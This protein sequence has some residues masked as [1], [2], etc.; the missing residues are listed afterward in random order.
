MQ[1]GVRGRGSMEVNGPSSPDC[2]TVE[3]SDILTEGRVKGMSSQYDSSR[4]RA[5]FW[6]VGPAACGIQV[7][8]H[9]THIWL[10]VI[11]IAVDVQ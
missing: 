1:D 6:S 10:V 8:E 4:N 5:G 7:H 2:V 3:F 9:L 11:T